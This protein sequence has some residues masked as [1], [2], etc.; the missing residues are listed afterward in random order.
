[1]HPPSGL[2]RRTLLLATAGG[3][4][5]AACGGSR[6]PT[7]SSGLPEPTG[8]V[9]TRW[10]ADP[11][12]RGSYS[13]IAVGATPDDRVRLAAS[14]DDQLFF[15][16]EATSK[17]YAATVHGALLSGVRAAEEVIEAAEEGARVIVIGAGIAGLAAAYTLAEEEIAVTVLEGSDRVGGRLRTDRSLGVALDLGASWIQGVDGNP[18]SE[19]AEEAGA[20][21][22]A[23][24]DDK[25]LRYAPDGDALTDDEEEEL[26]E[27][28]EGILEDAAKLAEERDD[29]TSLRAVMDE[30]T[31]PL[32]LD[33]T[34]EVL[35]ANGFASLIELEYAA[36][37][38]QLSAWYWDSDD[39][40]GGGDALLPEGYDRLAAFVADGLDVRR[41]LAVRSVAR[42][43]R[44]T[45]AG[46]W[47]EEVADHVIVTV[48]L[49][50]LKAGAIEFE[51]GLPDDHVKA[52]DAL[53]MGV[54]DKLYM[55]FPRVFWDNELALF[56]IATENSSHFPEWVNFEPV[57]GEPML[58]GFVAG[59]YARELE[60]EDDD[61]VVAKAMSV[62]GTAY[63]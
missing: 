40:F 35:L 19:L 16:G 37:L 50:V 15:A 47:G 45:V 25:A 38:A 61:A 20:P 12:T 31:E 33:E 41:E 43:D 7:S 29:D 42:D 36:D 55:R 63:G 13:Y 62:L 46:P 8:L 1:M 52:I 32:D 39:A 3:V 56:D 30:A 6:A 21:T 48:P 59:S 60:G 44:V 10:A 53:G 26:E 4:A 2:T 54:L 34:E 49:G 14:I 27:V 22:Y 51:P 5:M 24:D 11:W 23:F 58:M 57:L 17:D 9:R 28:G 18:V